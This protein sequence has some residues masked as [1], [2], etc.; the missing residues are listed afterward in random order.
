MYSRG[1]APTPDL[2][3]LHIPERPLLLSEVLPQPEWRPGEASGAVPTEGE[4]SHPGGGALSPRSPQG[5]IKS[6]LTHLLSE[7][8]GEA[9]ASIGVCRSPARGQPQDFGPRTPG[10]TQH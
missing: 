1:P 10:R 7:D 2:A 8:P 4:G 6:V 5:E 3:S 9:E